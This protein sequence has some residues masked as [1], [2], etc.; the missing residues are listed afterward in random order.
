M[1]LSRMMTDSQHDYV[2]G[3][4]GTALDRQFPP[5]LEL[6]VGQHPLEVILVLLAPDLEQLRLVALH[7]DHLLYY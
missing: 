5:S 6:V 7:H 3:H 4:L 2:P 1:C